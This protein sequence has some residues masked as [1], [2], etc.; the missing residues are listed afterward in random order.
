MITAQVELARDT[1]PEL[2]KLFPLHWKK[3]ALN[4]DKVELLPEYGHYIQAEN[5]GRLLLVTLRAEGRLVGYWVQF[6]APELHYRTCLGSKM[7]IWWIHPDCHKGKAALTLGRTVEKE[8]KR[9]GVQ[10]WYVGEKL[11]SPCG[12]LYA[13]LGLEPVETY[14][15]KWIGE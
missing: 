2:M 12:R 3:L 10:R 5:E 15:S 1:L 9:R 4:Q 13:L 14:Y 8:L 6:I 7:D 11:H